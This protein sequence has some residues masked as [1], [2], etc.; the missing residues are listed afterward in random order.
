MENTPLINRSMSNSYFLLQTLSDEPI[1]LGSDT[2]NQLL[3]LYNSPNVNI[4]EEKRMIDLIVD[5]KPSMFPLNFTS[6][7]LMGVVSKIFLDM[8]VTLDEFEEYAYIGKI[9]LR[10]GNTLI[11][12]GLVTYKCKKMIYTRAKNT[13]IFKLDDK[14]RVIYIPTGKEYISHVPPKGVKILGTQ[15]PGQLI[16]REDLLENIFVKKYKKL[17]V[18]KLEVKV[19]I[20]GFVFND[21]LTFE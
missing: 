13:S 6:Q 19:P 3:A 21:Y 15:I 20:D 16:V 8:I 12:S 4:C 1:K 10:N 5:E 7:V 2:V 18:S 11:D 9:M 17:H 14:G